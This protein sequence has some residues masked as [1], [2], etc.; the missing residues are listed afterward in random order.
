MN[1][2]AVVVG[3]LILVF[4]VVAI[5]LPPEAAN[6]IKIEHYKDRV[7]QIMGGG[8]IVIAALLILGLGLA[9]AAAKK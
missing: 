1:S 3:I 8:F 7:F 6:V 9:A 2:V 5:M 4:G